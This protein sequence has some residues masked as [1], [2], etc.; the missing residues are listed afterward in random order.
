VLLR[1]PTFGAQHID[2]AVPTSFLLRDSEGNGVTFNVID[3]IL[4]G[5][6]Q[7]MTEL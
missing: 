3:T 4:C 5:G 2:T 1:I 6:L 7:E